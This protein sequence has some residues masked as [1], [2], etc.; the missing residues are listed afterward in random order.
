M[1]TGVESHFRLG[2]RYA[3]GGSHRL[4]RRLRRSQSR[5]ERWLRRRSAWHRCR[6]AWVRNAMTASLLVGTA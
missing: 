6:V 1:G 2:M 4:A 3:G 5:R